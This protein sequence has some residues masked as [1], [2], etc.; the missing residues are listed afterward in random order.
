M[1]FLVDD[2]L[3]APLKGIRFIAGKIYEQADNEIYDEEG[4]KRDLLELYML[5]ET[6]RI[7]E[8]EFEGKE[9]ELVEQLEKLQELKK[10]RNC[11]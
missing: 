10:L 8:E 7:T 6:G 4:M 2:I 9:K 11:K 5:L 1:A 3:L